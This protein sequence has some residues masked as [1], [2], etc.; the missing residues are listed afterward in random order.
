MTRTDSDVYG[1]RQRLHDQVTAGRAEN[2]CEAVRLVGKHY[3]FDKF[4]IVEKGRIFLL[5]N[6]SPAQFDTFA[7]AEKGLIGFGV[8]TEFVN[9]EYRVDGTTLGV[10]ASKL[11]ELEARA[12]Y[13]VDLVE[14]LTEQSIGH[15]AGHIHKPKHPVKIEKGKTKGRVPYSADEIRNSQ[16]RH[17]IHVDSD[18][19]ERQRESQANLYAAVKYHDGRTLNELIEGIAAKAGNNALHPY[20]AFPENPLSDEVIRHQTQR[21]VEDY[22]PWLNPKVAAKIADTAVGINKRYRDMELGV[23]K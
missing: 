21:Y 3:G 20:F 10:S 4:A 9:G 15:E 22:Y 16:I 11:G 19:A 2:I 17:G 23:I 1:M 12:K 6:T 18:E 13:A 7:I 8:L 5:R 14:I